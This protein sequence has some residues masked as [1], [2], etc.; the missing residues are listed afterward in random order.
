MA[1]YTGGRELLRPPSYM[2]MYERVIIRIKVFFYFS[3]F[4]TFCKFTTS[5]VSVDN[6]CT[7]STCPRDAEQH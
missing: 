7:S 5:R 4:A 3:F 2:Y 1:I 6:L